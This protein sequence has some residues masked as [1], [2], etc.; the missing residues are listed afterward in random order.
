MTRTGGVSGLA[1]ALA[2]AG[3]VLVYSGIRN[4]SVPETL[5]AVLQQRQPATL[6]T[7]SLSSV[8]TPLDQLPAVSQGIGPVPQQ[9]FG[10]TGAGIVAAARRYLGVPYRWGGASPSGFDC[11]GLVTWVLHHDL[12]LS[13]PSNTHTVTG[14][15]LV[16]A[17]AVTH[18]GPPQPGDLVCWAGHIGIAVDGSR[19]IH[20]PHAGAVVQV[21][22][23][24][25]VPAPLYR[26]VKGA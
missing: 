7:G 6:P 13:L 22:N 14:Q 16:W 17:G 10:P 9:G 25:H 8:A 1:V 2:T 21:A 15:F 23:I 18:A 20:A 5:R 12:G 24:W 4:A 26:T 11:S 3:G 19:M